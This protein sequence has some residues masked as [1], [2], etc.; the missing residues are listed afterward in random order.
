MQGA[1]AA[2][3]VQGAMFHDK[4]WAIMA[5]GM[6]DGLI[7]FAMNA[8]CL[9][10]ATPSNLVRWKLVAPGSE[11]GKCGLCGK[12]KA[13]L[14]HILCL[15]P[16][17][18]VERKENVRRG[19]TGGAEGPRTTWRHDSICREMVLQTKLLLQDVHAR[20]QVWVMEQPGSVQVV[21][22]MEAG[23]SWNRA[24][25]SCVGA[26]AR[27]TG[28][29]TKRTNGG[30]G[31][32]V[33]YTV[34]CPGA[35]VSKGVLTLINK[36]TRAVLSKRQVVFV[37]RQS[38]GEQAVAFVQEGTGAPDR[39]QGRTRGNPRL[40]KAINTAAT[41]GRG[42]VLMAGGRDWK[43]ASDLPEFTQATGGHFVLP[44]GIIA[45]I[46]VLKPDM[47][48]FSR[49]SMHVELVE[50]SAGW[51]TL[52]SKWHAFKF[53]KY[54]ESIGVQAR[55]NGW[56]CRVQAWEIGCRGLIN[57]HV[58]AG[59][60]RLG[61][62]PRECKKNCRDLSFIAQTC[63]WIMYR[64]RSC[65]YMDMRNMVLRTSEQVNTTWAEP[66]QQAEG[67]GR[68]EHDD[69]IVLESMNQPWGGEAA[70][71]TEDI[72]QTVLS[73]EEEEEGQSTPRRQGGQPE[74]ELG[75]EQE[76]VVLVGDRVEVRYAEEDGSMTWY[77][78]EVMKVR[79]DGRF[80]A[81]FECDGET[82]EGL[83]M[84][85]DEVRWAT[86]AGARGAGADEE[87]WTPSTP[88]S[89]RRRRRRGAEGETPQGQERTR[90]HEDMTPRGL[91]RAFVQN[92][93]V[94]RAA[95]TPRGCIRQFL[96]E[97]A[98]QRADDSAVDD[99]RRARVAGRM[100]A[101]GEI[102]EG[103]EE[104]EE[105]AQR[106]AGE[107][108]TGGVEPEGDKTE[109]RLSLGGSSEEE[110]EVGVRLLS[111]GRRDVR[112]VVHEGEAEEVEVVVRRSGRTR[113]ATRR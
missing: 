43:V 111:G 50:L 11:D 27:F 31:R 88:A 112:V 71:V 7:K 18:E 60:R 81:L 70:K 1:W 80:S 82:A 15:C 86:G 100:E 90:G 17:F 98:T 6:D 91:V 83:L 67:V 39:G 108:R 14:H 49:E 103:L 53:N 8:R 29:V 58:P 55:A 30:S 97:V 24:I 99:A 104:L 5:M 113:R 9:T 48:I 64:Y 12:A 10:C 102:A 74:G 87:R 76:R 109:R 101:M 75:E 34:L 92:D 93:K 45:G 40:Q 69:D 62:K 38:M 44:A 110:L 47:V 20:P 84:G 68:A 77:S 32:R 73:S 4:E 78:G 54:D 37:C 16:Y 61:W 42:G 96:R 52:Q 107:R 94:A 41:R 66:E 23:Q 35:G 95:G 57:V 56:T 3:R 46:T 51:D 72:L 65:L 13:T 85:T 26:K 28:V 33:A 105:R 106:S 63:S 59:M 22:E 2:D 79:P 25:T 36:Q 21:L 89:A 19:V